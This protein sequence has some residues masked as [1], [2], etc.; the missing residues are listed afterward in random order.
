MSFTFLKKII[1]CRSHT[2]I[3][4]EFTEKCDVHSQ[5]CCFGLYTNSLPLDSG[6]VW[7]QGRKKETE[8]AVTSW[9]I[10]LLSFFSPVT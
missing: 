1:K 4:K 9:E 8:L 7:G 3:A 6:Q 5:S 10:K 2:G